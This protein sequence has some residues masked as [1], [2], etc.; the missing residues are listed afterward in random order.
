M[1]DGIMMP[2]VTVSVRANSLID[3]LHTAVNDVRREHAVAE[4]EV[5][6]EETARK[7]MR[8]D[9][10]GNMVSNQLRDQLLPGPPYFV[11]E[12]VVSR[13]PLL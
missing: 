13:W 2:V 6:L 3:E 8:A 9:A 12:F 5:V 1:G 11:R 10:A 4:A 7:R